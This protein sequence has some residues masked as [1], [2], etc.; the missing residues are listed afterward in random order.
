L[1]AESL[2]IPAPE[3]VA[4]LLSS[5]G[6]G[7]EGKGKRGETAGRGI[8]KISCFGLPHKDDIKRLHCFKTLS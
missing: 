3:E 2:F 4:Q 1:L 5:V 6:G 8:G 7:G